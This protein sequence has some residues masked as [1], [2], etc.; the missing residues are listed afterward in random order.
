MRPRDVSWLVCRKGHGCHRSRLPA[1]SGGRG[2][3]R[4]RPQWAARPGTHGSDPPPPVAAPAVDAP[5]NVLL[6]A[7]KR[8]VLR[9]ADLLSGG[10]KALTGVRGLL[11]LP[12]QVG[13]ECKLLLHVLFG[14]KPATWSG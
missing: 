12:G 5:L 4:G 7:L 1:G 3:P 8:S 14:A 2:G 9:Q 11:Y 10:I 6:V 13:H